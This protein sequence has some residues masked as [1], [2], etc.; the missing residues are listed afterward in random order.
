[1]TLQSVNGV[2]TGDV[3]ISNHA[4]INIVQHIADQMTQEW[5]NHVVSKKLLFA[6]MIDESTSVSQTQSMIIYVR[7]ELEDEIY[8][9]FLR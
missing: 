8:S 3:L 4:C 6:I 1:M 7:T 2:K 9:L 5:I